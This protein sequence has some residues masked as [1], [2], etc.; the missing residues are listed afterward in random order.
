VKFN[1]GKDSICIELKSPKGR[2]LLDK[3]LPKA[4]LIAHN[5]RPGVPDKLGFGYE[6]A[7]TFNSKVVWISANGFGPTAPS[8]D[9]PCSHPI[10]GALSGGASWQSGGGMPP[11]TDDIGELL[12]GARRVMRANEVNPDPNTSMIVATAGMLGLYAAQ[13]H[14]IGQRI[15][16]DMMLANAWAN[17]DDALRYAGKP[18]RPQV[19]QQGYGLH[20]LYRLYPCAR[21]WV[22][23]AVEDADFAAL[24]QALGA[25]A[26]ASDAR[27]KDA[28]ARRAN[29]AA[30]AEQL[31]AALKKADADAWE[32]KLSALGCVRADTAVAGEFW[33]P[34]PHI[35]ENGFVRAAP[36][37]RYGEIYRHGPL[38]A[39]SAAE[40]RSGAPT[41]AGE[42]TDALL[43]ELGYDEAAIAAL[44]AEGVVWSEPV[45]VEEAFG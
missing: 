33:L 21:G 16:V 19:D 12:E 38:L 4:D 44:R 35:R 10:A 9:S 13:R 36:H 11:A 31:G 22:F 40:V 6:R 39:F 43:R 45:S 3:L 8:A 41:L 24:C 34:D 23:L 20:A 14:G 5:F 28:A 29:D 27:F 42:H 15:N 37:K 1:V 18:E 32:K 7:R 30:L 25:N 2:E 26:L 17:F